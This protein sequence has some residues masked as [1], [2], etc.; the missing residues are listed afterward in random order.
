MQGMYAMKIIRV[1][2]AATRRLKCGCCKQL[3]HG[4]S[5]QNQNSRGKEA[6]KEGGKW[7]RNG[8]EIVAVVSRFR[9]TG[10]FRVCAGNCEQQRQRGD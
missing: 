2:G 7:G 1:K 5:G 9:K 4:Y 6:G 8:V 10:F 3:S